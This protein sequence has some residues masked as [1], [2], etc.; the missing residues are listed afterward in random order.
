[1]IHAD[2]ANAQPNQLDRKFISDVAWNVVS[3]GVIGIAGLTLN[4]IIARYYG[5]ST[6]GSFGQVFAFLIIAAQ[7]GV[8]GFV[9]GIL[10]YL[11]RVA[12]GSPSQDAVFASA[13][14]PTM[15]LAA[16]VAIGVWLLSGIL[17]DLLGSPS[18]G[19]GLQLV[20]P[21]I[22]LFAVNKCLLFGLNA[23]RSMRL[24]AMG[25]ALRLLLYLAAALALIA[26]GADG[27]LLPLCFPIGE[28]LLMVVLIFASRR[29]LTWSVR[30]IDRAWMLRL[31]RYGRDGFFIGLLF[32]INLKVDI[33][34][35]G[36]FLSDGE[37]G[38]YVF[39]ALF[40]DGF[41]QL[42][43]ILQN[44][45]NPLLS[46]V[47]HEKPPGS[48]RPYLLRLHLY[49]V[50]PMM[51]V[52]LGT[53]LLLPQLSF[54]L[55]GD[56]VFGAAWP[57][58]AILATGIAL[59][60]GVSPLFFVFNQAGRPDLQTIFLLFSIVVNVLGNLILISLFGLTGAALATTL[61]AVSMVPISV[62][63]YRR[64]TGLWLWS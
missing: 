2:P 39:M 48:I 22:F 49:F 45:L 19:V 17:G 38:L 41:A 59:T 34:M 46:R 36:F 47:L 25:Q 51:L 9:F 3:L 4:I 40:A 31:V 8:G 14:Y 12:K 29:Q 5:P 28:F 27:V 30:S 42:P 43:V 1:M 15:A 16:V 50:P 57:L 7:A 54:L 18:T 53:T 24:F 10:H 62:L 32:D 63:L 35:L 23:L 37:V 6:L 44:N 55:T 61:T 11:P 58:F 20:S 56:P 21:A 52:A 60:S 13:L 33:I 26:A 64:A